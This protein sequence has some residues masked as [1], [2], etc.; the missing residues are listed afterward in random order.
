MKRI[1]VRTKVMCATLLLAFSWALGTSPVPGQTRGHR[2]PA[3]IYGHIPERAI[4]RS[5]WRGRVAS[6]RE[7]PITFVLPLRNADELRILLSR[8]YDRTDPMYGRYLT[9]QQFAERF[10]PTQADYDTV[11]GYAQNLGF[12]ITG[13]HPNRTLLDVSRPG[14]RGRVRIQPTDAPIRCSKRT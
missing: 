11:A 14:C 12:M 4:A 2:G 3:R 7:I 1:H 10:A 9:P 13:R 5:E 8:I 6:D